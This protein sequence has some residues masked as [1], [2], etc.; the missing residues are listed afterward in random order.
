MDAL[1]D[2]HELIFHRESTTRHNYHLLVA[3]V[4]SDNRNFV[5][6]SYGNKTQNSVCCAI[7]SFEPISV[8]PKVRIR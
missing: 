2:C 7:L 1:V 8:L 4:T 6:P 5:Y 3:Q